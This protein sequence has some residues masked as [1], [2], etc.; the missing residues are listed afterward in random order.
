MKEIFTDIIDMQLGISAAITIIL[1]LRPFLRKRYKAAVC[2][3]M[4]LL[5]AI[6]L[7]VPV[8]A[9][10][11][12]VFT[13]V[14]IPV[15]DY[16]VY[17][18]PQE[19]MQIIPQEQGYEMEISQR[20]DYS[21]VS[22][23]Q[24]DAIAFSDIAFS[25]WIT[26]MA[27]MCI[28]LPVYLLSG[29]KV[30]A[31][32]A[33]DSG[34]TEKLNRLKEKRRIKQK[35]QA[36]YSIL[37]DGPM[38]MGILN[39]VIVI[40]KADYTDS[41]LDMI[42]EHEL[43]HLKRKDVLF[44]LLLWAGRGIHWFN[45]LVWIMVQ[46]AHQDIELACDETVVAG[47]GSSY[48]AD[49]AHSI[50]YAAAFKRT[51]YITAT[52]FT[53]GGK[54]LKQRLENILSDTIRKN[55]R[56]CIPLFAMFMVLAT[57]TVSC[58]YSDDVHI[59][60]NSLPLPEEKLM[61]ILQRPDIDWTTDNYYPGAEKH[62][63]LVLETNDI[64]E[65]NPDT[66]YIEKD[67]HNTAGLLVFSYGVEG[68]YISLEKTNISG[69]DITADK[70]KKVVCVLCRLYGVTGEETVYSDVLDF[71]QNSTDEYSAWYKEYDGMYIGVWYDSRIIS[72]IPQIDV[73]VMDEKYFQI[74]HEKISQKLY[75]RSVYEQSAGIVFRR[76]SM[77][78]PVSEVEKAVSAMDWQ[79]K[80]SMSYKLSDYTRHFGYYGN[81]GYT[82]VDVYN[83]TD[84][85]HNGMADLHTVHGQFGN[86]LIV[87]LHGNDVSYNSQLL[88][89]VVFSLCGM[90]NSRIDGENVYSVFM[91]D[92]QQGLYSLDDDKLTWGR[93]I[94]GVYY[95]ALLH[96]TAEGNYV[97]S[98]SA[99]DETHLS[100]YMAMTEAYTAGVPYTVGETI[101]DIWNKGE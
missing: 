45:P 91:A 31:N 94:N 90:Y 41:Q 37:G 7:C 20:Q 82:C 16:Y 57:V 85:S 72:D 68:E 24:A 4:W 28:L 43:V 12:S 86:K 100:N 36:V 73:T 92:L 88:K 13:P 33:S 63:S 18:L 101:Q 23:A 56:I 14:K 77:P 78:Q 65:I 9:D 3:M 89:N 53:S 11:S 42:I 71:L 70:L 30:T 1:L 87:S 99:E 98:F 8:N 26:G 47:A 96:Q 34:L 55:G 48:K 38:L 59:N 27:A 35:V 76:D 64:A 83:I 21:I 93:M 22:T 95:S 51:G 25:V 80:N 58:G 2:R 54:S 69:M 97:H 44:K 74:W 84:N 19:E 5:I 39:P 66:R 67:A 10:F 6:R 75:L 61:E 60:K 29:K 32:T 79:V 17:R 46:A 40:P 49:Y 15:Q 81:T 62:I 52:N 50:V